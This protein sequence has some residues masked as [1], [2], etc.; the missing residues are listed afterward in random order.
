MTEEP[1]NDIYHFEVLCNERLTL[2]STDRKIESLF[3]RRYDTLYILGNMVS[4]DDPK[5]ANKLIQEASRLYKK[6]YYIL[7]EYELTSDTLSISRI[8]EIMMD[9]A[10]LYPNVTIL[11]NACVV[12]HTDGVVIFGSPFW[13]HYDGPHIYPYKPD[14]FSDRL[15]HNNPI[16]MNRLH[17]ES[18]SCLGKAIEISRDLNYLLIV[19]TSYYPKKLVT[20]Q[21]QYVS[22]EWDVYVKRS[23]IEIWIFNYNNFLYH[24]NDSK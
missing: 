15:A 3:A 10:R 23:D 18:V 21:L 16:H 22:S 8:V 17:Y 4:G 9:I 1:K 19:A 6:V 5:T 14:P 7:G 12:N 2:R 11:H 13:R 20:S 24:V